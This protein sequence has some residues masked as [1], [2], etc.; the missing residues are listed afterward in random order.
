[1][2]FS[3][4]LRALSSPIEIGTMTADKRLVHRFAP[5]GFPVRWLDRKGPVADST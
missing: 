4:E 2:I 1:M 3:M 5:A